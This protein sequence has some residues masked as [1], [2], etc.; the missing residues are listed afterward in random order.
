MALI[1]LGYFMAAT[2]V[3]R[4]AGAESDSAVARIVAK[5]GRR[6]ATQ[7][8]ANGGVYCVVAALGGLGHPVLAA[9][10]LGALAASSA[11]TWATVFGIGFGTTPRLITTGRKVERGESG[12]VTLAGFMGSAGGAAIIAALVA[13]TGLPHGL[14]L[15]SLGGGICGAT[16]DSLLGATIQERRWCERCGEPTERAVH[17]CGGASR[18]VGGIQSLDN[19]VINLLSTFAGLVSGMAIYWLAEWA[20]GRSAIG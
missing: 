4:L 11:D 12:G 6:D 15:A 18:L 16:A 10:A 2:T 7:V 13:A 14:A 8:L 17:V 5:D 3:S 9:G 1:L 19:D 20:A